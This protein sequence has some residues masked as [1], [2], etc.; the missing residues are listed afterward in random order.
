MTMRHTALAV[1][2]VTS[3]TTAL[4]AQ[5]PTVKFQVASI[6]RQA[7]SLSDDF[8]ASAAPRM[9]AGGVLTATHATVESLMMFA[10]DLKP[11]QI[12]EGPGWAR[13]EYFQIEARAGSDAPRQ[14]VREMAQSL[15]QDRFRL[16]VRRVQREMRIYELVRN[17]QTG[18]G[19]RPC[20]DVNAPPPDAPIR[21]PATAYPLPIVVGANHSG[22]SS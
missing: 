14:Q 8:L 10:Y 9:R 18:G 22:Q 7:A 5:Q 6:K 17:G 2:L 20:V 21:I 12:V 3:A 19:L 16:V 15:L 13:S 1:A 11:F 4:I